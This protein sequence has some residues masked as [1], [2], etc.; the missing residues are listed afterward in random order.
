MPLRPVLTEP[1][2]NFRS[3]KQYWFTNKK[4][5]KGVVA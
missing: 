2:N 5:T 3:S 4:L 1:C